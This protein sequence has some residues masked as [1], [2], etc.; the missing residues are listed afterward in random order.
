MAEG[1]K[2]KTLEKS[3]SESGFYKRHFTDTL[4]VDNLVPYDGKDDT[5]NFFLSISKYTEKELIDLANQVIGAFSNRS[6]TRF[7][8]EHKGDELYIA[9]GHLVGSDE[10]FVIYRRSSKDR[11]EKGGK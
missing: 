7:D 6:Y 2:I 10:P 9:P 11:E 1:I 5:K 8:H 3:L 4:R